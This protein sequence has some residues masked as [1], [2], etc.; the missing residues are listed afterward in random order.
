MALL[1]LQRALGRYPRADHRHRL[2]H[3]GDLPVDE[4]GWAG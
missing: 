2:E 3:A 1:A 4:E